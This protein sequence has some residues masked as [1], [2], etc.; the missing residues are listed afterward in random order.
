MISLTRTYIVRVPKVSIVTLVLIVSLLF[1]PRSTGQELSTTATQNDESTNFD[2]KSIDYLHFWIVPQSQRN[3]GIDSVYSPSDHPRILDNARAEAE[4]Q[5]SERMLAM[6]ET[7][8]RLY[9]TGLSPTGSPFFYTVL[10]LVQ[11]GQFDRDLTIFQLASTLLFAVGVWLLG[12][13]A[14]LKPWVTLAILAALLVFFRPLQV[15]SSVANSNRL[16]VFLFAC[17]GWSVCKERPS[18]LLGGLLLGFAVAFK[19][20]FALVPVFA[21]TYL[22]IR[23]R[24]KN[25]AALALGL[26]LGLSGAV[27]FGAGYFESLDSWTLWQGFVSDTLRQPF[28]IEHGN[29]SLHKL[30]DANSQMLSLTIAGVC[31]L[32]F[33]AASAI[34]NKSQDSLAGVDAVAGN[35]SKNLSENCRGLAHFA[36]SSEQNVPVPLSSKAFRIGSSSN[37]EFALC[38][39]AGLLAFLM[40]SPLVW[41]HYFV[42]TVP[43]IVLLAGDCIRQKQHTL[44][45]Y[46]SISLL[47]VG[48]VTVSALPQAWFHIFDPYALTILMQFG[49][50]CLF[51][52]SVV[53]LFQPR[54]VVSSARVCMQNVVPSPA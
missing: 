53:L 37:R 50:L 48:T 6:I 7:N 40:S 45:R 41:A 26:V 3:L 11:T 38:G 12:R 43:A 39:S 32:A 17:F 52:G 28:L 24:P 27:I 46:A 9:E 1:A 33:V 31:W 42:L 14:G 23:R 10:G 25:L 4:S 16:L 54:F 35:E 22:A 29:F 36:E 20:S 34:G 19:P 13:A 2:L 47:V 51:V 30:L 8:S 18:H 44:Q 5:G 49:T 21:M 15:D